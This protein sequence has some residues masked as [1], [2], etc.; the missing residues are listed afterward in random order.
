MPYLWVKRQRKMKR[1]TEISI[2][3][4]DDGYHLGYVLLYIG[5]GLIRIYYGYWCLQKR[6]QFD[7]NEKMIPFRK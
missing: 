1:D 4:C 7:F 3:A 5:E 6:Q 2:V